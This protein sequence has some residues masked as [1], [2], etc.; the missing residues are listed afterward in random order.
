MLTSKIRT[1][2]MAMGQARYLLV[3]TIAA[4]ILLFGMLD[5]IASAQTVADPCGPYGCAPPKQQLC[6]E[7][8]SGAKAWASK[9][10]QDL[11][12]GKV[13][14]AV[15]DISIAAGYAAEAERLG[16]SMSLVGRPA[17]NSAPVGALRLAP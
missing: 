14:A 3:A 5:S 2:V 11:V 16:C 8:E 1:T 7:W 6:E 10:G 4:T 9:A 12:D 17:T 15:T 13:A